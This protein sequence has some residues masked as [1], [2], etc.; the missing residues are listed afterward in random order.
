MDR[1]FPATAGSAALLA[2]ACSL[3][4]P[5][6]E[7]LAHVVCGNRFFPATLTMDDPGVGDE[8]SLPTIQYLP[9]PSAGD[10]PPGHSVDYGY[11][12]DKR[13]TQDL[14]I[15]INGDY[16]TQQGTAQALHGWNNLTV[17]LKD[18]LPC[19]EANEFVMSV[20]VVRK[21]GR[22]GSSQLLNAG[23]IDTISNTAPTLYGGKGLGDLPIGYFRPLAV[24]GE[25]SYQISDTPRLSPNAWAYAASLQYSMP[26]LQQNVKDL[27][28]PD[29]FTHLIPL[30]EL[31]YTLAGARYAH[32]HHRAGLSL[33]G[34]SP[35]KSGQRR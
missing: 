21:F 3:A 32:G 30:V 35:G 9:I 12:F 16:F 34:R 20:G 29:F 28:L 19:S 8:L 1:F 10:T 13:L 7:A 24:T 5:E 26:Y 33:R 15:A 11:E 4:M 2:F 25:L 31:S 27:G 14:G 22:T 23:A 18:Q 6:T 17:T